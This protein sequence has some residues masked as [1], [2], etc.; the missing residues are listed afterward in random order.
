MK[1]QLTPGQEPAALI[2]IRVRVS[3]WLQ[4]L[5]AGVV[6]LADTLALGASGVKPMRVRVSPSVQ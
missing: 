2:G 3:F 4:L 5:I 1:I 6:E